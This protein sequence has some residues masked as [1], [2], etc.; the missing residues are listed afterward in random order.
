[1]LVGSVVPYTST[2]YLI[3]SD[4][5]PSKTYLFKVKAKNIYGWATS[6]S[7]EA[8]IK[9]SSVPSQMSLITTSLMGI[10]VRIAFTAPVSNGEAI[11]KY[12]I[13]T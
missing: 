2:S 9:P 6:F 11:S 5:D 7:P 10:N 4:I 3:S 1:M 8:A 13:L 12:Q